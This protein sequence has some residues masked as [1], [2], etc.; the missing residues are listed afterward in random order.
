ML[1]FGKVTRDGMSGYVVGRV[2]RIWGVTS[3][4]RG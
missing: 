1:S 4:L 2:G 3:A